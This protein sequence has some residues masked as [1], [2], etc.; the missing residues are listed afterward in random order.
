MK[1]YQRLVLLITSV[2][3]LGLFLIYRHQYNRLH[4]VLE[5]FNFFGTPCN[6]SELEHSPNV[7]LEHDWGP[8]PV[9]QAISTKSSA[10][11]FS[12]FWLHNN[13]IKGILVQHPQS[14]VPKQCYL[15]LEN[16]GIPVK[17]KLEA[18]SIQ[19][20]SDFKVYLYSCMFEPVKSQP[21]AVGFKVPGQAKYVT[22]LVHNTVNSQL[23]FN[24]TL[25]VAPEMLSTK[26]LLEFIS[27]HSMLG[28]ESFIVY[29]QQDLPHRIVKLLRNFSTTLN[30]WITF[31]PINS[32]STQSFSNVALEYDC[33]LRTSSQTK[34]SL[35]LGV[36]DY[37]VPS[38]DHTL[39]HSNTARTRLPV[40][41]FCLNNLEQKKPMVLQNF[42]LID[43]YKFNL[44]L[45][46]NKLQ[47]ITTG[48]GH[49][50][51]PSLF[52]NS[53]VLHRYEKCSLV[54]KTKVDYSMKRFS[55]DLIR[56]TLMQL[57]IHD[58]F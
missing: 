40:K 9:W 57:L 23:M 21:Y 14:S 1:K 48:V 50:K 31:Y 19:D 35:F 32:P 22:V 46:V 45:E 54:T 51:L 18:S 38:A 30:I 47:N 12:A 42:E 41:Q 56:S 11:T 4:Q 7:M 2:L 17:G 36:N 16:G 52:E 10:F 24:S 58:N 49:T 44:V 3:S 55:E 6:V 34:Y 5:V 53:C 43:D 13:L 33:K 29:H 25:C 27:F 8:Q 39:Q 26:S 15:F 37:V 28:V 20:E